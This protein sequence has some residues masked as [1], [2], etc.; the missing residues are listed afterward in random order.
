MTCIYHL[1]ASGN[2]YQAVTCKSKPSKSQYSALR[3]GIV[4]TIDVLDVTQKIEIDTVSPFWLTSY[5]C[6]PDT[7]VISIPSPT[8]T[9]Y[10]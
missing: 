2:E 10:L 9:G 4:G 1:L 6:T 8:H 3:Q 5:S 7:K